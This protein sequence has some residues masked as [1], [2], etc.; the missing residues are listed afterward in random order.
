M[1]FLLAVHSVLPFPFPSACTYA[2]ANFICLSPLIIFSF[3]FRLLPF[4]CSMHSI[5]WLLDHKLLAAHFPYL[6]ASR[7]TILLFR[8]FYFSVVKHELLP[9]IYWILQHK[10]HR[11]WDDENILVF[12]IVKSMVFMFDSWWR[13]NQ[14]RQVKGKKNVCKMHQT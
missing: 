14:E 2:F 6:I 10:N 12:N 8:F 5:S 1:H 3:D 4:S 7:F 13:K 9:S 11:L